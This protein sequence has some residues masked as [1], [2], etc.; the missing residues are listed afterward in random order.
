MAIDLCPSPDGLLGLIEE[1]DAC[2]TAIDE[3]KV[4]ALLAKMGLDMADV[5][6]YV[7][8]RAESYSRRCVIRRENFEVLVLTWTP[9][10]RSVAHDHAGSLC[11]LK[12]MQGILTERLFEKGPDGRVRE[13]MMSRHGAGSITVDPGI[14]IHSLANESP[15]EVL[16]TVH[17]YSPPLPEVRRYASADSRPPKIFTRAPE[18]GAKVIAIVGGGFTGLMTLAN[19]LRFGSKLETP[20]H[21]V[22]IDR[23]PAAGEGSAYRTVDGR[24]LLNVPANRMSAWPDIPDDFFLFAQKRNPLARPSDFLP[25][26]MYGEYVR[27]TMLKVAEL[28]D[29][30]L[31]A[32]VLQDEVCRLARSGASGWTIETTRGQFIQA[33]L[34]IIAVGHRPPK[35]PFASEWEGPRGRFVADPWASLVLSQIGPNEPVLLI[36]SGLTSVDVILTLSRPGRS[37]PLLAISRRGLMPMTHL[38]DGNAPIDASALIHEWLAADHELTT[39]KLVTKLLS[40]VSS[41]PPG[42]EWQQV[43]DAIRPAIP[44]LWKRLAPH[45]RSRFLRHVRGFWEIHRHRMAPAIADKIFSLREDGGLDVAAGTLLS[46]RADADGIDVMYS[47][48]GLSSTKT[49]RVSWV[50][51]CTGPGAHN[52]H[53]T[54]AFLRPL[55]DAGA[56]VNDEH[57]LGLL[58]D[59]LGRAIC[60]SG[61]TYNDL[62]V[63]GTLRKPTLWESTAVPELRAQSQTVAREALDEIARRVR[64][65]TN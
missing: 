35:D 56:L 30:N 49:V 4:Y 13:M 41:Q 16:V 44:G 25:R 8:P 33:D 23:Q 2:E 55:L 6:P 24:H 18:A 51:N 57:C 43:I 53:E 63:A 28:A 26:K 36:G 27:E 29:E 64:I 45:E 47:P 15:D 50:V 34:A 12:V 9:N 58:T 38:R 61:D 19:L 20:L 62:F 7:E 59:P 48:R 37:A 40:F 17:V 39:R 42:I 14:L 22:L 32:I 5:S 54:H 52:R 1:L 3:C 31:C 10:Q 46:A 60:A 11:G 65:D 21:I